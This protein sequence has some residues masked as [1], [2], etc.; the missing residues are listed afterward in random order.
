MAVIAP[1][2][3]NVKSATTGN[4][5]TADTFA[6]VPPGATSAASHPLVAR[7]QDQGELVAAS[8]EKRPPSVPP[9][10]E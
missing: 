4:R 1:A 9:D 10:L 7:V 6:I 5:R 2:V 3:T 8:F